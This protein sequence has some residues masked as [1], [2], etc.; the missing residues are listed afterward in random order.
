MIDKILNIAA[1]LIVGIF[2]GIFLAEQKMKRLGGSYSTDDQPRTAQATEGPT[3]DDLLD[4]LEWVESK[5]IAT[6]RGANG[7][8]GA[9]QLKPIYVEDYYRIIGEKPTFGDVDY[10]LHK[11]WSRRVTK[12]VTQH[13]AHKDHPDLPVNS[14]VFLEKA[15]R[16][17]HRPADRNNSLT[18]DYWQRIKARLE[19]ESAR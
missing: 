2:A 14:A 15:A 7:E 13:Y 4:A 5:G 12:T 16:T 17:H 1:I 6:A 8:V 9:Y 18:D 19:N 11:G 3:F 10:R